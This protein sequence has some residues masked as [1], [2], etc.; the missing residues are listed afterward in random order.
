M[1]AS[2]I[3]TLALAGATDFLTALRSVTPAGFDAI[4][5]AIDQIVNMAADDV[6]DEVRSTAVSALTIMLSHVPLD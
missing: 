6:S 2:Q 4:D 1:E 5:S 3:A